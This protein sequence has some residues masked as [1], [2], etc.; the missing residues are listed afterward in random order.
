MQTRH[1]G[2]QVR[3]CGEELLVGTDAKEAWSSFELA[4]D[5]RPLLSRKASRDPSHSQ[6]PARLPRPLLHASNS[7]DNDIG[8]IEQHRPCLAQR[9]RGA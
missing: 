9:P 7:K 5:D 3:R 2:K 8:P 4:L 6:P 1:T